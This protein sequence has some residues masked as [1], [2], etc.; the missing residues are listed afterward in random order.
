MCFLFLC[1]VTVY[2]DSYCEKFKKAGKYDAAIEKYTKAIELDP[3]E[4]MYP[5]NRARD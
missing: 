4:V 5:A 3:K 1:F 2:A